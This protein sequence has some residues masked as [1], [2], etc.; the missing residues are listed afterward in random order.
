MIIIGHRWIDSTPFYSVESIDDIKQTPPNTP[1][2]ILFSENNLGLC[3]YCSS[4]GVVFGVG[5]RK[6]KEILFASSLGASYL[7]SD[8]K[9]LIKKAQKLAENY[10]FDMK[11]LLL[12][13]NEKN[14]MW[15]AN[16]GVDGILFERGVINGDF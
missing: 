15:A 5:I 12:V 8:S 16:C 9:K 3:K 14:L 7:V 4:N 1:V 11:I 10:L 6:K 13:E 2:L